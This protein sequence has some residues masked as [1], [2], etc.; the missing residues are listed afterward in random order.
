MKLTLTSLL[1]LEW[2]NYLLLSVAMSWVLLD[3]MSKSSHWF[4]KCNWKW[5]H[6]FSYNFK[7]MSR[8]LYTYIN[9]HQKLMKSVGSNGSQPTGMHD[10]GDGLLL[11]EWCSQ[12]YDHTRSCCVCWNLHN[13]FLQSVAVDY[14]LHSYRYGGFPFLGC[15]W[16]FL[17]HEY[18][19]FLIMSMEISWFWS[20]L[21]L[22]VALIWFCLLTA[23]KEHPC[24]LR[25][26]TWQLLIH[27]WSVSSQ[28]LPAV[29]TW[30]GQCVSL[31]CLLMVMSILRWIQLKLLEFLVCKRRGQ[32]SFTGNL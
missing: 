29:T 19:V 9:N 26:W 18:G 11:C 2:G 8:L 6:R 3:V 12:D 21:F 32:W 20:E 28:I 30:S 1:Q 31:C 4:R 23:V 10:E 22:F 15:F 5:G 14:S 25:L 27:V 7:I 13:G 24:P 17:N 16:W